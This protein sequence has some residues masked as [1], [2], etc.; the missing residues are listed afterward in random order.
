MQRSAWPRQPCACSTP[1]GAQPNNALRFATLNR[2]FPARRHLLGRRTLVTAHVP[3]THLA[4]APSRS[5]A[6]GRSTQRHSTPLVATVSA[7]RRKGAIANRGDRASSSVGAG[8][9]STAA[10][11]INPADIVKRE[12]GL[13]SNRLDQEVKDR[14]EKAIEQ[15]GGRVTAGDVA[16]K[17]G[18]KLSEADE[19]LKALAYD[20]LAVLEVGWGG[21]VAAPAFGQA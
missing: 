10:A 20:T 13:Q 15:L 6:P 18:V 4:R 12:V 8:S 1:Y 21:A 2:C 3:P 19:C 7:S 5:A 11:F 14:V 16:A 9:S 17:A